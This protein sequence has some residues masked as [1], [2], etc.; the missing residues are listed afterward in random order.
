MG[1]FSKKKN[2]NPEGLWAID[3]KEN[4][5]TELAAVKRTS[6]MY[7]FVGNE[8][9][10]YLYYIVKIG[11]MS[12]R[13]ILV[14]DNSY[15]HDFYELVKKD[16]GETITI[17]ETLVACCDYK[18]A[19]DQMDSFEFVFVWLGH[20]YKGIKDYL[21]TDSLILL[22]SPERRDIS[23]AKKAL[24]RMNGIDTERIF[25]LRDACARKITAQSA[26]SIIETVTD[27]TYEVL[28]SEKDYAS[29]IGLTHNKSTNFR[30]LSDDM[31]YLIRDMGSKIY[32]IPVKTLKKIIK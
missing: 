6:K 11:V 4:E 24:D 13:K 28:Y 7:V 19:R 9:S 8:K 23:I 26:K 32:G 22:V 15:N 14:I 20:N 21:E 18:I 3:R 12:K 30:K 16:D 5:Q 2:D 29:Y 31:K 10:D 27:E 1:L 17:Q 25:I